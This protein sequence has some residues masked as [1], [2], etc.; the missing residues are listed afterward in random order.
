MGEHQA[1]TALEWNISRTDQDELAYNSHQNLAQ[2]Y[3]SGFFDDL[4][5][6]YKGL[7]KDN[8]LRPDTTLEKISQS[9][10]CL[11]QKKMPIQP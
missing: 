1:I 7:T 4:I 11:W 2:A 10:T 6:P 5:T 8:N 9:K 3:E